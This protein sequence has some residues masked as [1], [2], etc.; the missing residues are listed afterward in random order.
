MSGGV[1]SSVSAKLLL[2]QG[3]QVHG[4]YLS[5]LYPGVGQETAIG[6]IAMVARQ[7]GISW[8]VLDLGR[9]PRELYDYFV[10]TYRAGRTPN[11][12]V[13]CNRQ[14]KFGFFYQW[15]MGQGFD[16]VAT[17]HYVRLKKM[18]DKKIYVRTAADKKKDQSYFLSLVEE[19]VW[20]QAI[21]PVGDYHKSDIRNMAANW[22]LPVATKPESMEVCFLQNQKVRD[23]LAQEIKSQS[24][25]IVTQTSGGLQTI[26]SHRGLEFYTIGQR[27]GLQINP[28]STQTPVYYVKAK[29][30]ANNRLI[31]ATR[32]HLGQKQIC[33]Q[34]ITTRLQEQLTN[35]TDWSAWRVRIR[36]RGELLALENL[37]LT[38]TTTLKV[39]LPVATVV[40]PGQFAT[41]YAPDPDSR[42]DWLVMGAGEIAS[43]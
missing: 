36:H 15:A 43:A 1:D 24:G 28:T 19:N 38:S 32:E 17:G 21:F 27:Q 11:V 25:D 31:V 39:E 23:F 13:I 12:C 10:D 34:N 33:L 42:D 41:F 22:G 8:E 37:E 7:L 16:L 3:Y 40:S 35:H 18:P 20:S 6:D 5:G 9:R 29:D 26:G 4:V 14:V 2:E 30:V